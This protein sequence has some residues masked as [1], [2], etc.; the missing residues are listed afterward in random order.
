MTDLNVTYMGLSLKNPIIIGSSGLTNS[1]E[2]I[3]KLGKAGAAAVVL[4]SL[5]EEQ[6]LNE[7]GNLITE[8]SYPEAEDYLRNYV[9]SN[10]I[11]EYLRLIE[12]VKKSVQIPVIASI[13]CVSATEWISFAKKIVEAG[14][15][16]LE[17]NM[18]FLPTDIHSESKYYEQLY[19]E[20]VQNIKEIIN[21]PVA[22]KLGMNFTSL[23]NIVNNI[24]YR[25]A[26]AVVLF[27]RY[28]SPDIDIENGRF[29][30]SEI[31][32]VPE[33]LRYS[34]R[35]TG[36]I[37]AMVEKIDICAS[38]G[39]HD[40]G[41]VIKQLLAGA[42]AVQ[43]CSTVYRNGVERIGQILSDLKQWMHN[44]NYS[45][46]DDF[47]GEM[48]YKSVGDPSFFERSQFMRY[49]TGRK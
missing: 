13:N 14:A 37:S 19:M 6:I 5:F 22:V 15:D 34:L 24:Y 31:L 7:S 9:K 3:K 12:D 27:N 44:K 23:P 42:Q 1:T 20:L 28:Y 46:I 17:L 45:Q 2:K 48:N 16:G 8:S 30:S 25:G 47:R 33:D 39:I 35:W 10:S 4:K 41:A 36:I 43:I 21:I 32:S 49:F 29:I 26:D 40:A 18:Y 38:M 11:D